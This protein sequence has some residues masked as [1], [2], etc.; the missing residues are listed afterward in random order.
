M[1]S[2]FICYVYPLATSG[3]DNESITI[4]KRL[5]KVIESRQEVDNDYLTS[6]LP[7]TPGN[8]Y[9]AGTP[10]QDDSTL[11]SPPSTSIASSIPRKLANDLSQVRLKSF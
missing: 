2:L 10:E 7:T 6:Q 1:F 5:G 9:S 8:A 11:K 3:S 4:R